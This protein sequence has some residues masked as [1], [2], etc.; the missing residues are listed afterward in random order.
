MLDP[1][2]AIL[3]VIAGSGLLRGEQGD[4]VPLRRGMTVLVPH[5]AG[6]TEITGHCELIRCLPPSA[7]PADV[8][9]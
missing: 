2:F 4:D 8:A 6:Q 5:G 7:A 3:I 1:G 9:P